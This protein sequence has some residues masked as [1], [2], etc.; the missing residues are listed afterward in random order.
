[1]YKSQKGGVASFVAI[2]GAQNQILLAKSCPV[3]VSTVFGFVSVVC[4]VHLWKKGRH[5]SFLRALKSL[6]H[7]EPSPTCIGVLQIVQKVVWRLLWRF[8]VHRIKF[9]SQ[10][11]V[12]RVVSTIFEAVP[13]VYLVHF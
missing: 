10:N 1:M 7:G 11:H 2:R 6:G 8:K 5:L 13:V 3:V 12:P 4:F 9:C